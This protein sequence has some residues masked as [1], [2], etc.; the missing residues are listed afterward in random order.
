[1]PCGIRE[2]V[3]ANS[4]GVVKRGRIEAPLIDR[5]P[6]RERCDFNEGFT[7]VT[8]CKCIPR[9]LPGNSRSEQALMDGYLDPHTTGERAN[10]R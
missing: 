2:N 8:F 10:S 3:E 1:M 7:P 4:V 6:I 5:F 9:V